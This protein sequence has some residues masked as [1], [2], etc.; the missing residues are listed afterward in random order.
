M[1]ERKDL[2]L[3]KG[4]IFA[5][6][7]KGADAKLS[8][9]MFAGISGAMMAGYSGKIKS[10][11]WAEVGGVNTPKLTVD[12]IVD[13]GGEQ[14]IIAKS[15]ETPWAV[16]I[17]FEDGRTMTLGLL[18]QGQSKSNILFKGDA[19]PTIV[20]DLV[21]G[22]IDKKLVGKTFKC[23]KFYRDV[24]SPII[25]TNPDGTQQSSKPANCY[26]FIEL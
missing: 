16:T 9:A 20:T 24:A 10:I 18:L 5:Q 7:T 12:Q 14:V 2:D 3:N 17:T 22:D 19:N 6:Q 11:D 15:G 21:L 1:K 23:T 8:L 26:E 4:S 25:R 13:I